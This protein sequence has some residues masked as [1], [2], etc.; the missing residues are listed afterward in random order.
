MAL[1]YVELPFEDVQ[2]PRYVPTRVRVTDDRAYYQFIVLV[3]I[4]VVDIADDLAGQNRV[5][6]SFNFHQLVTNLIR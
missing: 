1:P 4:Q 3:R 6:P 5:R 2:H